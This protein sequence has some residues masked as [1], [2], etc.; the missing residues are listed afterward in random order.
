[1]AG[2][3]P[4]IPGAFENDR[5]SKQTRRLED[6]AHLA[7]IRKLPSIVSGAY[8]CEACHI[9]ARSAIHRKPTTGIA[10]K[11]DDIWTLP[12][13]P[14]E[15]REQHS[16]NEMAFWRKH[17]IDPFTAAQELYDLSGNFDAAVRFINSLRRL[18]P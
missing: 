7:F 14:A 5:A 3:L 13:T 2:R 12:L 17:D 6:P 8:G 10:R 4:Y 16:E 1:M 9:R 15:H 11:P 18:A